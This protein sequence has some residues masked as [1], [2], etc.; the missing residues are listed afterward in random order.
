MSNLFFNDFAGTTLALII[1]ASHSNVAA[2]LAT[3][4]VKERPTQTVVRWPNGT[5]VIPEV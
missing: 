3:P 4:A 1:G 2:K 5:L